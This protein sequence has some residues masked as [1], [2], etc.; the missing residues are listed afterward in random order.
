MFTTGLLEILE[1]ILSTLEEEDK[2]IFSRL[3]ATPFPA[4]IN[5]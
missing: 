4:S 3:L 5:K 1:M 2:S